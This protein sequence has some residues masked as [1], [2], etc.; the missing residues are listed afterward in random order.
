MSCS[1]CSGSDGETED[2]SGC[3]GG[4]GTDGEDENYIL[5]DQLCVATLTDRCYPYCIRYTKLSTDYLPYPLRE[6]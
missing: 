5:T 4:S 2:E 6:L 1:G 3:S